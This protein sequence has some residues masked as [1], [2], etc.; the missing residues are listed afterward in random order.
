MRH[1]MPYS[2]Q[3]AS[4]FQCL[5]RQILITTC[6]IDQ[7]PALRR[8]SDAVIDLRGIGD[9]QSRSDRAHPGCHPNIL[10][11]IVEH[12]LLPQ[13]LQEVRHVLQTTVG[14]LKL[15]LHCNAG[16]HRCVGFAWILRYI[17]SSGS[18]VSIDFQGS[19]TCGRACLKG[20]CH[21]CTP[22]RRKR[23]LDDAFE[24]YQSLA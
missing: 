7:V 11:G 3:T 13:K 19:W 24:I 22:S 10:R 12:K 21:E 23:S 5:T 16:K 8:W 9:P 6:S 15:L 14:D 18:D 17:L 2:L 4:C 20:E 1:C